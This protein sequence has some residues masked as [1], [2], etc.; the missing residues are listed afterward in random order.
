[1]KRLTAAILAFLMLGALWGCSATTEES[2]APSVESVSSEE[3]SSRPEEESVPEEF[4]LSEDVA[5]IDGY[6]T[7]EID[8]TLKVKNVFMDHPYT[9]NRP[10]D[11]KY[12]DKGLEKLTDCKSMDVLY[13]GNTYVGWSGTQAIQITFDLTDNDYAIGDI[14]IGCARIMDYD[15]NLP[16]SVSVQASDDGKKF[17]DVGKIYTPGDLPPTTKYT[18]Y[19][20]FP[21]ALTADYVRIVLAVGGNGYTVTD[22]IFAYQYCEDGL[23]EVTPEKKADYRNPISDFYEYDLNLGE[24]QV[25][26]SPS[27]TD[28]DA[29]QNLAALPGVD[30]QIQH[31]DPLFPGHTNSGRDKLYLLTD[32]KLHG[33]DPE[34]DYFIFYRGTGRHVVAD[35]GAVMAVESCTVSFWDKPSWGITTPPVYY[36]SVSE[37]GKD[38]VTVFAEHYP[39][40]GVTARVNDLREC[41]FTDVYLARYVRITFPT[42]P[43]NKISSSVYMGEF[44]IYGTKNPAE[45]IPAKEETET[46]YGKY[47]DP[48]DF[49][50]SDILWA[51]VGDDYGVVC[52][53]YHV[54]TEDTAY[55]Y[56]TTVGKN[57]KAD[58]ALFDAFCFTS[59][60][61][62]SW[63]ADR[64]EGYTW[65]LSEVFRDGVN[66]DALDAAQARINKE[67]GTNTKVP[68]F[69]SVNCPVI[70]D[71]FNGKK[72][73]TEDDYI[74]CMIWMADETIKAFNAKK[75]ENVYLAGFYWQVE[76]LR[77]NHWSPGAAHDI[78]TAKAFNEYV[79]ELGYLSLWLPYYSYLN[80]IWHSHYYGFDITC[81]QP[82]YVFS[83]TEPTRMTTI[84]ELSKLYG[85]GIEVEFEASRQGKEVLALY[86]EYLG[87]GYEYGMMNSINAYY[88]GAV[89]GAFVTFRDDKDPINKAI[90]EETVLYVQ[91]ELD[92]DPRVKPTADLSSYTDHTATVQHGKKVSVEL[93]E[94]PETAVQ[95][96]M[97]PLYGT[98][99]LNLDGTLD[100]RA[101]RGY[102]GEDTIKITFYD[103][104]GGSKTITVSI[105]VTE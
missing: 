47:P 70:G 30:F 15:V 14:A 45:A 38:W 62:L 40:Y 88:Q 99:R 22:E 52:E 94:L 19:F 55:H 18:Y 83:A 91:G 37:N 13:G 3:E 100:Y 92:H 90:Y 103:G 81:W 77:P 93:G 95:F 84:A 27:D 17:T 58:K 53:D 48:E 24:S 41:P 39:G 54:I 80:G 86:R 12:P 49:G 10:A 50:F 6:M 29:Y 98:V 4:V 7:E 11:D 72:I 9:T 74:E 5:L 82:N 35:L 36:I 44:E 104:K 89:P 16:L 87:M 78:E 71:T 85:V 75:Y 42:V 61:S 69:V 20:S 59:R 56:L 105:T 21:K 57:G 96:A 102:A 51:G 73:Q 8:R 67:K 64:T 25:K 46:P 97:T 23:L 34:N 31:F 2:S 76:N 33:D 43:D 65:Y 66:M 32:G 79:H 1:M 28:Y 26:V 60:G 63:Y 101:M 68:A